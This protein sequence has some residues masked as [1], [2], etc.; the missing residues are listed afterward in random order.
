MDILIDV[1]KYRCR[2]IWTYIRTYRISPILNGFAPIGAASQN[3]KDAR[4][5]EMFVASKC[6]KLCSK[7][8]VYDASEYHSCYANGNGKGTR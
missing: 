6:S 8:S 5:A 3:R 1:Q 2:D 7:R 4:G